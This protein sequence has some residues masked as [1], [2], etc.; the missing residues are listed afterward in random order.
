M[1]API[2][3]DGNNAKMLPTGNLL[4][5][6]GNPIGGYAFTII[7]PD[8]GTSPTAT[9]AAETLILTSSDASV[10]I[11]GNSATN[12]INLQAAASSS[13]PSVNGGSGTPNSITAGGGIPLTAIGYFNMIWVLGSGAPVTVTKTPSITAGTS[14]GQLLYVIAT[15]ATNTVTL[16]DISSLPS[17]GLRLNGNWTGAKYMMLT[18]MWN[19]TTSEWWEVART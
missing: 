13:A 15:H 8:N 6:M 1:G 16:Q 19:N 7:Q 14:D 17:S 2:I 11:T 5:S 4:N 9:G 12:T 18:L 10:T 3:W